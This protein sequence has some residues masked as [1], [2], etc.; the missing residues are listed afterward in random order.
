M[1]SKICPSTGIAWDGSLNGI[2]TPNGSHEYTGRAGL[3]DG[4]VSVEGLV[5]RTGVGVAWYVW[6][7]AGVGVGVGVGVWA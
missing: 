3:G 1:A 6:A 4:V 5:S 7:Y 2:W